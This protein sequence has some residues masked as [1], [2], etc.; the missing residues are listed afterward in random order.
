MK[1][2]LLLLSAFMLTGTMMARQLTPEEALALAMGKLKAAQ[3]V[4]TRARAT[5]INAT[6]V[7]LT[8]TEMKGQDMPLYYVYDIAEGGFIIASADDSAP[9]LLGYTD[10]GD[11]TDAQQ[12]QSLMAWLKDCSKALNY[13]VSMPEKTRSASVG[14][15]ALATS[16]KPLLG[17]IKWNQDAP[18]NLLTPLREGYSLDKGET[19]T[20][21]APTGCVATALAQVMKYH[22]WPVKGTGSHT[23][24]N[25]TLQTIDFSQSTYQWSKMLP[26][27]EGGESEES[28]LAVAQ[29]LNDV[30]CAL[31][32][33]YGYNGSGTTDDSA[34]RA[35][36]DHFGY[37]KSMRVLYRSEYSSEEWNNLLMTEL[38]EQRPVIF[39]AMTQY[40]G[41]HEFVVDGYDTN[42]L[43]H[44]NWGLG[45]SSNGYFDINLMDPGIGRFTIAQSM[46]LGVKPDVEGTS[47]AKP[48]LVIIRH[49]RFDKELQQW[50]YWV[51]NLGLGD[52][53]GEMG[54]AMESPTG[55]VTKLNTEKYDADPVVLFRVL[56][57]SFDAPAAPGPGYKLYPYYCDV[58]DGEIKRIPAT[59][60]G[61]STLYSV[62][63]D[64]GYIWDC[65]DN[66]IADLQFV[67]ADVKHNFVGFAPQLNII[68]NN[69]AVSAKEYNR[70]ISVD[71]YKIEENGEETRVC[72]G[73]AQVF[74]KPGQTREYV[75]KCTMAEEKIDAGVYMYYIYFNIGRID[76][77]MGSGSFKMVNVYPSNI[78]YAD[79]SLDKT[80]FRPDEKLTA[81]MTVANTG[82]Y[83]EKTLAF[84]VCRE[85]DHKTVE[86]IKLKYADIEADSSKT[87]T[88]SRA[89]NYGPGEY[90]GTFYVD[91]KQL[92]ESPA[93]RFTV[94]DPTN[95]D[96]I[97]SAPDSDGKSTTY[98]LQGRP[99]KQLHKGKLYIGKD[100]FMLK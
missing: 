20:V 66:E 1:R 77:T 68:L 42:G 4:S 73:M 39:G 50:T 72:T 75:V 2:F 7:S 80:E 52:F 38:N 94:V 60:N 19:E 45:G 43:Y 69:P 84:V 54:I 34:L 44:V 35:M 8:H 59:Y 21:H 5:G 14:T 88:F 32:M 23:N 29:L 47:V 17:E 40:G 26:T 22:Q 49:F 76:Y 82:G 62:E 87:F 100:K 24:E 56:K 15:R 6:R 79:F 85:S 30:G 25:D 33:Y 98:D 31:D 16:V 83:D 95:L 92:A 41:G 48:D 18:Y 93:F 90:V 65:N 70:D 13:I 12:N 71:I 91:D 86:T 96:R 9:A 57:N 78:T 81:S 37:D 11:F 74:I 55:E 3:P 58:A 99:V 63:K 51:R 67:C 61:Y 10:S 53:T 46:M 28:Q 89:I 27:Y 36:T 97:L 64:G